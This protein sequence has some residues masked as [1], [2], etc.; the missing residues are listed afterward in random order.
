MISVISGVWESGPLETPTNNWKLE[1]VSTANLALI[2]DACSLATAHCTINCD[3]K[4]RSSLGARARA[5]FSHLY[6]VPVYE[7]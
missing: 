6:Q 7:R 2:I 4:T 5:H 1:K 3:S